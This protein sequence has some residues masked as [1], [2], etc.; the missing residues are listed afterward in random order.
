MDEKSDQ[1]LNHIESQ[2]DELG[3]NLDELGS[4]V[5]RTTD[6]RAHYQNN[7]AL[8]LGLAL[9]GGLIVGAMVGGRSYGAGSRKWSK[10][11]RYAASTSPP[12]GLMSSPAPSTVGSATRQ[13]R[14]Q[15]SETIDKLKAAL[16]AFGAAK[17]KDFLGQAVPG[18]DRYVSDFGGG[19]PA[20]SSQASQGS[21]PSQASQASQSSQAWGSYQGSQPGAGS[22]SSPPPQ[23]RSPREPMSA[24]TGSNTGMGI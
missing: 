23:E 12:V 4:R 17:A 5:K 18:L 11:S 13:A 14:Q 8:M 24:G 2:R 15:A 21:Q 10:S 22:Q 1:I 19:R 20:S 6:W 7:P 16:I 9:G 3:R